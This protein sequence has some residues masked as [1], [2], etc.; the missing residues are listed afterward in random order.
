VNKTKK[1]VVEGSHVQEQEKGG[2]V[3]CIAATMFDP[4]EQKWASHPLFIKRFLSKLLL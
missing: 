3:F 4:K 1:E 2:S